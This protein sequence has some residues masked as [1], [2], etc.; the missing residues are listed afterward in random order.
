MQIPLKKRS[1]LLLCPYTKCTVTMI[2]NAY[3]KY[4]CEKS[5]KQI[6]AQYIIVK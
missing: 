3:P 2:Y 6:G 5:L 1:L 4:C